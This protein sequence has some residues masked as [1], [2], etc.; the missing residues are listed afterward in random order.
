ME[1]HTTQD[2]EISHG[3]EALSLCV[4]ASVLPEGTAELVK[5]ERRGGFVRL[6][7][8]TPKKYKGKLGLMDFQWSTNLMQ[9]R[10]LF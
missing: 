2:L 3:Q 5:L 4:T 9:L 1:Q 7:Y 8:F 6:A 10:K